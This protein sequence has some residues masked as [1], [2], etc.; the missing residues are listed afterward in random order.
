MIYMEIT[1]VTLHIMSFNFF[2]CISSWTNHNIK[3]LDTVV[4]TIPKQLSEKYVAILFTSLK[5]SDN[6]TTTELLDKYF[7]HGRKINSLSLRFTM[8]MLLWCMLVTSL[9]KKRGKTVQTFSSKI[10]KVWEFNV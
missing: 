9:P 5:F 10:N 8:A 4:L 1:N 7:N 3:R 2:K 6:K